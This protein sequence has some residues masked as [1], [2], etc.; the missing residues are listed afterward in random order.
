MGELEEDGRR[1]RTWPVCQCRSIKELRVTE[2][3]WK[4]RGLEEVV[5][6]AK[7]AKLRN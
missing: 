3:G 6:S 7:K 5:R 4:T 1:T 2:Y